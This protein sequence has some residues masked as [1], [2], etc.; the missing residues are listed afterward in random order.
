[1]SISAV[2]GFSPFSVSEWQRLDTISSKYEPKMRTAYLRAVRSGNSLDTLQLRKQIIDVVVEV[3][4]TTAEVYG[5]VFNSNSPIYIE[6]VEALTEKYASSVNSPKAQDAVKAVL[7]PGLSLQDR[8]RRLNTFGLDARSAISIERYRQERGDSPTALSDVERARKAAIVERGNLL[9]ITETNRMV[10]TALEAVWLDNSSI[11]KADDVIYYDRQILSTGR[12]PKRA[13]KEWITR[14][15][16]RVCN[17][18]FP[19]EG[20]KARLA[21]EFD[22]DYGFFQVPPIHPRCRC[23][24]II[25]G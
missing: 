17:Y 20:V 15:D 24:M 12:I 1:M 6:T 25:T 5:L 4:T 16:D 3:A 19:L 13:K 2:S 14:R 10:N 21:E 22:T 7:P 9:A 18:C 8:R 23:F 11:S